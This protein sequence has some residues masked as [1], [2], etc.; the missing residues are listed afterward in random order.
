M[1][2]TVL[3]HL[4]AAKVLQG[5]VEAMLAQHLGAVFIPCGLGHLIGVDTHDVG[6]YLQDCPPRATRRGLS[7]LRTARVLEEGMVL[8]VE[9]GCYFIDALLDPALADPAL[10]QFFVLD[11]IQQF[12]SF[13]GVRL[14]D[15]VAVTGTGI[16]NYTTCPRTPEEVEAVMAG[17]PWPPLE[18]AAPWMFRQ[19]GHLDRATGAM[20]DDHVPAVV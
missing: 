7:K 16:E 1:E 11:R 15:V 2:R 12:R 6:G 5:D 18:D 14:E 9:P 4:I 8:T 10:A 19:W 20:A 17:G 3:S 13:G